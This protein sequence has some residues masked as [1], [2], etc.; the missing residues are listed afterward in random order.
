MTRTKTADLIT[1]IEELRKRIDQMERDHHDA[2]DALQC[3]VIKTEQERDDARAYAL[4]QRAAK[5]AFREE[6]NSLRAPD[7]VASAV[8]KIRAAVAKPAVSQYIDRQGRT[9]EKSRVGNL[10][11][12]RMLSQ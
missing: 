2:I 4:A 7:P 10:T 1:T 3:T 8:A 11:T 6:L 5:I 12:S 9:W